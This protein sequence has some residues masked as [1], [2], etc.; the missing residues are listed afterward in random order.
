M[1][2]PSLIHPLPTYV[3]SVNT[4]ATIQD[5]GYNEPVQNV[6]YDDE[7]TVPGQWKWMSDKELA[8][9]DM[10]AVESSTGYVL[11]RMADLRTLGKQIKRGDRIIGYGS[12]PG[13]ISLDVYVTKLRYEGHY[14]DQQGPSLVK[15][16]FAD[17]SPERQGGG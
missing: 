13:R 9:Q 5:T 1:P 10:G 14:P 15:V 3:R 16:Y 2:T 4:A 6:T 17:R 12:G 8:M 7:F 11:M